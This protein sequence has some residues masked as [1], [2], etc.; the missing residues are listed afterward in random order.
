MQSEKACTRIREREID[1]EVEY[2]HFFQD[3]KK[4]VLLCDQRI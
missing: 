2:F 4:E 3:Q 1:R